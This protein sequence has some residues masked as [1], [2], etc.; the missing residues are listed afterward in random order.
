[1]EAPDCEVKGVSAHENHTNEKSETFDY[2]ENIVTQTIDNLPH[3][4]SKHQNINWSLDEPPR[5][6]Y[7]NSANFMKTAL[8]VTSNRID[9]KAEMIL[10]YDTRKGAVN[11]LNQLLNTYI[12]K[13]RKKTLP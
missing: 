8:R 5:F 3:I 10:E 9:I 12:W 6:G 1:M 4:Q 7:L 11:T 13:R 2:D